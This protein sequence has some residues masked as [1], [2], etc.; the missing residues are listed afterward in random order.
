M[1]NTSG[2]R[3]AVLANGFFKSHQPFT[4]IGNV[5]CR[6]DITRLTVPSGNQI[7]D[8]LVRAADIV[9]QTAVAANV[10]KRR[11]KQND[12]ERQ[13]GEFPAVIL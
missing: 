7:I 12:R 1:N 6:T 3:H 9:D 8:G 13:P 4:E 11:I 2:K 10:I 5:V